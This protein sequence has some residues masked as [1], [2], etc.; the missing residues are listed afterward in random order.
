MLYGF[1][2]TRRSPAA[3]NTAK[4]KSPM[5]KRLT[6]FIESLQTVFIVF[7]DKYV[8]SKTNKAI[9]YSERVHNI[10]ILVQC[11]YFK[12]FENPE[13]IFETFDFTICMAAFDF[14][15]EEF[16]FHDDFF[17]NN[18]SKTLRFNPNTAYPIVSALRIEK[19]KNKCFKIKTSLP[20][21][22]FYVKFL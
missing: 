8:I 6:F 19:Y 5:I 3:I 4:A 13:K 18:M 20:R 1:S 2:P 21:A 12:Y 22:N 14:D 10:D 9:M 11:I 17:R 7:Q 16:V 15:T